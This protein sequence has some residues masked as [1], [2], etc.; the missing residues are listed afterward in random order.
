VVSGI[1]ATIVSTAGDGVQQD[2][3]ASLVWRRRAL[4]ERLGLRLRW[5]SVD[6]LAAIPSVID[7]QRADVAFVATSWRE[8]AGRTLDV[9]RTLSEREGRPRL[10]YLDSFD[11]TSS[12]FFG[13]LPHVDLYVKKQLLREQPPADAPPVGGFV[14]TDH[15]VRQ[16]GWSIGDW[17][18]G[19][20]VPQEYEDRLVLGWNLGAAPR[21]ARAL[22]RHCPP[23][24]RRDIDVTCRVA[25]RSV[26]GRDWYSRHR[27]E[28]LEILRRLEPD[29]RVV[30]A[31]VLPG[32]A[33]WVR[34]RRFRRELRRTCLAF[35]PFGWGELC[36]R[37]FEA[38][39]AGCLLVKPSVDHLRT[40]PD[41]FQ[42]DRTYI[43]V[44]WDL[45]DL[46]ERCRDALAAPEASAA[47][48]ERARRVYADFF[49][50]DGIVDAVRQILTR[51]GLA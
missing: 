31:G 22:R 17:H 10:V 13:L 4:R 1:E 23:W 20:P 32:D 35:S 51:L 33:A 49:R 44:R 24:S 2:M 18:F 14:F 41:I 46:E 27:L 26:D 50:T 39:C 42:P 16:R 30:T 45:A 38:V 21:L 7:R 11:S 12:P 43:P 40:R 36:Y 29:Y 48:A 9:F 8:P 3:V 47:T 5:S 28:T 15:L 19:S 37:D 25:L 34:P 6:D